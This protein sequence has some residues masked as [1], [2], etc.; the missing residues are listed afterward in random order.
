MNHY[1]INTEAKAFK[2]HSPHDQWIAHRHAFTS[3]D[4]EK[5]GVKV[6]G[7]LEPCDI[8]FMYAKRTGIVAVGRVCE[9]WNGCCYKGEDRW[10][11]RECS[12]EYTEYRIPV[13]W[14]LQF[15]AEPISTDEVRKVFGWESPGWG[16]QRTLHS[17]EEDQA[18]ELLKLAQERNRVGNVP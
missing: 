17:I 6:L 14:Y 7:K 15:I 16:W 9:H 11:Y 10:I 8:C 1:S 4:H 13:D 3:G 2:G 5:Y 12:E 18:S